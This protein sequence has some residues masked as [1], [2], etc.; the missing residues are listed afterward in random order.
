MK[1]WQVGQVT[2]KYSKKDITILLVDRQQAT[3]QLNSDQVEVLPFL[4]NLMRVAMQEIQSIW[5]VNNWILFGQ[6]DA[7]II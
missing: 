1:S 3:L 2:Q 6:L 4:S 5:V 7:D